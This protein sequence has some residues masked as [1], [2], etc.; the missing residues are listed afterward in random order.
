MISLLEVAGIGDELHHMG[1]NACSSCHGDASKG[2][3]Y[4][5]VPGVCRLKLHIVDCVTDPRN[6]S[7]YKVISGVEI[8]ARSNPSA[9]RTVHCLGSDIIISMFGDTK[10][11]ASGG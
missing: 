8:K 4:L 11:N 5:I 1:W 10:G 7:L 9:L 2:H 3:R 6:L